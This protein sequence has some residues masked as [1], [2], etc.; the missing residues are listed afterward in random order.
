MNP[1]NDSKDVNNFLG[2]PNF[3]AE[4]EIKINR[5]P[6]IAWKESKS[7]ISKRKTLRSKSICQLFAGCWGC[8]AASNRNP[9]GSNVKSSKNQR[10]PPIRFLVK[11]LTP[12]QIAVESDTRITPKL[13]S[14]RSCDQL[15]K[16]LA[17]PLE[18]VRILKYAKKRFVHE[19][20]MFLADMLDA[21]QGETMSDEAFQDILDHYI[22]NE[23][24][25]SINISS[26]LRKRILN[27]GESQENR[28]QILEEAFNEIL[29]MMV[30][31]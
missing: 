24:P 31:L 27:Q 3:F 19:N 10:P 15:C 8:L 30:D 12:P 6:S 23:A 17:N 2:N 29:F 5:H 20:V 9:D 1:I 18:R 4:S 11:Q 14:L 13:D 28:K 22:F 26:E 21:K 16:D 25:E 7:P